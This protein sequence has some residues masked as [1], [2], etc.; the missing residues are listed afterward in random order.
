MEDGKGWTLA[1]YWL[2]IFTAGSIAATITR[3]DYIGGS[4]FSAVLAAAAIR[5]WVLGK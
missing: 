4:I 5:C 2:A 1:A 3:H